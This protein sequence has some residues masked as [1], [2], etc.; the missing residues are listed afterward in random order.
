MELVR[1]LPPVDL[2]LGPWITGGCARKLWFGEDWRTGDVD[3][4]FTDMDAFNRYGALIDESP[5]FSIN[6]DMMKLRLH[7]TTTRAKTY[8]VAKDKD[9]SNESIYNVAPKQAATTRT[10]TV[11][12]IKRRFHATLE[13]VFSDF[14][15]TVCKFATDG[16]RIVACPDAIRDC[17]K[18]LLIFNRTPQQDSVKLSPKRVMKY[19]ILYG[20]EATSE[21]MREMIRQHTTGEIHDA[22]D[23]YA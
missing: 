23:D 15:F 21:V 19:S 14:D 12:L 7:M 13:D 17:E 2:E 3:L 18:R 10:M 8:I 5:P 16:K 11:Q 9:S 4:F 20:F 22:D 1:S 6:G